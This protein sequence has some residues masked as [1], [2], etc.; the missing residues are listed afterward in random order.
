VRTGVEMLER[1]DLSNVLE[2]LGA[3]ELLLESLARP[4]RAVLLVLT[5]EHLGE[6]ALALF[7][8]HAVFF[9][10]MRNKN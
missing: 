5:L 4:V 1:L 6:G 10:R 7:A 9:T 8:N 2:L 3:G